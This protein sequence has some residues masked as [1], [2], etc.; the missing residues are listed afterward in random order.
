MGW[1]LL[2]LFLIIMN[3]LCFLAWAID[4]ERAR[5][6]TWR[7]PEQNLL[8]LAAFGGL[9]GAILGQVY[10][11]HKIRKRSFNNALW[12]IAMIELI[13]LFWLATF[14]WDLLPA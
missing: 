6:R 1:L 3:A 11:R 2:L 14:H 4:K 5:R 12:M 9:G 13:A 8:L 10:F 7:I